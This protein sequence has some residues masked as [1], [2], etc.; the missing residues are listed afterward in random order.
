MMVA[1]DVGAPC[2]GISSFQKRAA[3]A[4]LIGTAIEFYDFVIYAAAAALVFNKMFFPQLSSTSGTVAAFGAFAVGFLARPL[5][6]V[7]AGHF[8]DRFGRKRM[9][10]FS[11]L[12]MGSATFLVGCLPTYE[13]IALTAP[14]CWWYYVCYKDLLSVGSGPALY[15][16]PW[17]MPPPENA[18][19]MEAGHRPVWH[20]V[21]S[22]PTSRFLVASIYS[23]HKSSLRGAG[24]FRSCSVPFS[25]DWG[26]T[27]DCRSKRVQFSK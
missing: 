22:S 8:G 14:C 26:S 11:I 21:S 4:S 25:W 9:L 7:L 12:L 15:S 5:G 24:A 20:A 16:W 13:A 23:V 2:A 3:I 19:F 27:S 10:I 6:S 18:V 17:S 1:N